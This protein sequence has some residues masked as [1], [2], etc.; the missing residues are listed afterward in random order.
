MRIAALITALLCTLCL[1]A[2]AQVP[3]PKED[4]RAAKNLARQAKRLARKNSWG[5]A[6]K[7]YTQAEELHQ[8][9][10]YPHA[11][12][13]GHFKAG[14]LPLAWRALKRAQEYEVPANKR[15]R[16]DNFLVEVENA[17]LEGHAYVELIGVPDNADV[18]INSRQWLPPYNKWVDKNFSQIVVIH[19]DYIRHEFNWH[20]VKG[21]RHERELELTAA[22]DYGRITVSGTP[23]GAAVLLDGNQV[24]RFP[25]STTKLLKPGRYP[26]SV[27][28][29][30]EFITHKRFVTVTAGKTTRVTVN[31]EP[32]DS[33]FVKLMKTPKF[34]GWTLAG[35]GGVL[36]I[37]GIVTV[38]TASGKAADARD[39]NANH[40]S[41]FPEYSDKYDE[42]VSGISGLETGGHV[43]LWLGLA[44]A[45]TGTTLLVLDMMEPKSDVKA[46]VQWRIV[47]APTGASAILRF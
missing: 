1:S 28:K 23:H 47:P 7:L 38:A 44:M 13:K 8:L 17:L 39:L 46:P 14:M 12:A 22:S 26:I 16:F 4:I 31:L 3:P 9:W 34:W 2:T 19:P 35:T 30:P 40:L 20:H 42:A 36:T 15:R 11:L 45:G 18:R 5:E 21:K 43:M 37:A 24:G 41:G 6:A 25:S 10:V 29:A 27:Q 33:D 32:S